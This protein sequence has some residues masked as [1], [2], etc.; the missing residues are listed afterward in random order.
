MSPVPVAPQQVIVSPTDMNPPAVAHPHRGVN[1]IVLLGGF[2]IIALLAVLIVLVVV[3]NNGTPS[4]TA[5][6]NTVVPATQSGAAATDV[7]ATDV[8]ATAA[9]TAI[10]AGPVARTFGRLSFNTSRELGD[11]VDLQANGLRSPRSGNQYAVWLTNTADG[12]VLPVGELDV[13]GLGN[14]VLRYV[15]TEGNM[16]AALY[17]GVIITEESDVGEEPAGAVIYSGSNPEEVQAAMSEIF[18]A[19]E[20]GFSGDSLFGG[21]LAEAELSVIHTSYD[22]GTHDLFG[23]HNRTEHT[24]NILMGSEIDYDGND[25]RENPG[26][27]LGVP[28]F[29]DLI[30]ERLAFDYDA[31]GVRSDLRSD[32]TRVE[33]CINNTKQRLED[34]F[35]METGW[36]ELTEASESFA[37]S[38]IRRSEGMI[39]D[40][41]EGVD[42]NQN[43]QVEGFPGECGLRQVP[44]FGL[45]IAHMN[46]VE[47]EL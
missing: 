4:S 1:P 7:P 40:L 16:L 41:I 27:K 8:P 3:Q 21:A 20:E 47:G 18:V 37:Q 9:P 10:A 44:A 45:L 12:S 29:L 46:L 31:D 13:D 26:F 2:A 14:G 35:A 36:T 19:S 22:H 28:Y 30:K 42:R 43:G 32:V 17:N 24:I 23:L 33:A 34:F 38:E 15:D 39:A 11:T 6:I 25:L 5:A